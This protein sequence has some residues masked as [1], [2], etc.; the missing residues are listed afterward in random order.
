MSVVPKVGDVDTHLIH[1]A[2]HVQPH[3]VGVLILQLFTRILEQLRVAGSLEGRCDE[4]HDLRA[5]LVRHVRNGAQVV[6]V[7]GGEAEIF[8]RRY[9]V[10][11]F[12]LLSLRVDADAAHRGAVSSGQVHEGRPN[13]LP[14]QVSVTLVVLLKRQQLELPHLWLRSRQDRADLRGRQRQVL[15]RP[16][17]CRDVAGLRPE[18]VR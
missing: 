9:L 16:A 12:D 11:L 1:V 10:H 17:I 15:V 7:D 4:E 5:P 3:D 14:G 2:V 6:Q 18:Q 13:V 8:L